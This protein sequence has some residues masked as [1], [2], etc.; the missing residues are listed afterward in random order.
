MEKNVNTI[1]FAEDTNEALVAEIENIASEMLQLKNSLSSEAFA[2]E[3]SRLKNKITG[4]LLELKH[5]QKN[6]ISDA[7]LDAAFDNLSF[8]L[9]VKY[10]WD[11]YGKTG[12]MVCENNASGKRFYVLSNEKGA[13]VVPFMYFFNVAFAK[14]KIDSMNVLL[15]EA[16]GANRKAKALNVRA[17]IRKLAKEK[18]LKI[19]RVVCN[20]LS[21][22]AVQKMMLS[23]GFADEDVAK[24]LAVLDENVVCGTEAG[25]D[26]LDNKG[27]NGLD[28][29]ISIGRFSEEKGLDNQWCAL[30]DA[31]HQARVNKDKVTVAYIGFMA[32]YNFY[33][34]GNDRSLSL[35]VEKLINNRFMSYLVAVDNFHYG[36][37]LEDAIVSFYGENSEKK[38][39]KRETVQKNISKTRKL[40][41]DVLRYGTAKKTIEISR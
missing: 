19:G 18:N 3:E 26:D 5:L 14:R 2:K 8:Y 15:D 25:K 20:V 10:A 40:L 36:M 21:R 30:Y 16:D 28:A 17:A 41:C 1:L 24:V 7:L 31:L 13:E 27:S 38:T 37:K 39:P 9:A 23:K 29:I 35:N 12:I 4:K 34:E 6:F 33:A 11:S 22:S 32:T